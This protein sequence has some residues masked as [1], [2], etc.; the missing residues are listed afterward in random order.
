MPCAVR[1]SKAGPALGGVVPLLLLCALLQACAGRSGTPSGGVDAAAG[2]QDLVTASDEKPERRRARI[3]LELAASYF[4]DD[5]ATIALD[6]IK[7]SLTADPSYGE[8][9]NLRGLI[10]MRLGDFSL[11]EDSFKRAVALNPMDADAMHNHGWL[12]CEQRRY[13]EADAL[14]RRAAAQPTY[15]E[16]AKTL[17]TQGICE[18]RAGQLALAEQ[19][20]AE[21]YR[22]DPGNPITGY[23]LA[24]LL[25][26]RGEASRAQFYMRRIN[27]GEYATADSLWL[28]IKI[29]RRLGDRVA[30]GQLADQLRK[31]FPLSTERAALDRGAFDE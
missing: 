19:T 21:S 30:M 31:R 15:G 6:E 26:Q 17:M 5:K 18:V 4:Q 29:E 10:Y 7:Q 27:N 22:L 12:L 28:G 2:R 23:T 20:L 11:A 8:A 25:F 13:A 1:L 16:K 24:N 3:R 14:F 9:Y